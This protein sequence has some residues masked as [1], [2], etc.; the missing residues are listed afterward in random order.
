MLNVPAWH[1][2]L[3]PQTDGDIWLATAF[4]DYERIVARE[5][6]MKAKS[7]KGDLSPT[8]R[9]E[10]AVALFAYQSACHAAMRAGVKMPLAE[11]KSSLTYD[12][13]YRLAS[14]KGVM[15]LHELRQILG[16]PLFEET[17]DS[18]GKEH[19]GKKVTMAQFQ[20]HVEQKA[21]KSLD[22]FFDS[23]IK[24][25]TLPT[26]RLEKILVNPSLGPMGEF[27]FV[28]GEIVQ[29]SVKLGRK[30]VDITI[31]TEHRDVTETIDLK[32]DRTHFEMEVKSPLK[33]P[34]IKVILDKYGNMPHPN[35][36]A[37]SILSFYR[38]QE[39]SLIVYGTADEAAANRE[40][41]EALQKIIREK[42]SNITIPIKA[43]KE[44]TEA[45]LKTH[46]LLLVGRP[47]CNRLVQRFRTDLPITFGSRS[48]VV[49]NKT[50]AHSGSA[51]VVAA[52]NPLNKRFSLVVL[53]GLSAEATY[54]VPAL[55]LEKEHS[56]QVLI[57]PPGR[58][59]V[60]D[61]KSR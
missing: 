59:M 25:T 27:F 53:A 11:I 52:D 57:L 48:L 40:A 8:D 47:D 6:A 29:D 9:D 17:M 58:N 60:V 10:L 32:G 54:H 43:D 22:W 33:S 2:T 28:A 20:G 38:E 46:H 18:F 37:F 3:L 26:L 15:V 30:K 7:K 34:P 13:W 41:A 19:A 1:G 42:W 14:G 49:R 51:V 31:E 50:Y 4:A 5:K 12:H 56:A 23:R 16:D 44:V 36:V 39:Q 61:L 55:F 45:D 35:S 24:K 21:K